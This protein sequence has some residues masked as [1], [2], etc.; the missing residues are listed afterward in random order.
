[1][2]IFGINHSVGKYFLSLSPLLILAGA[3]RRRGSLDRSFPRWK[4]GLGNKR[5]SY[6]GNCP[7]DGYE[8]R[9]LGNRGW[10]TSGKLVLLRG[11]P[12]ESLNFQTDSV[13]SLG[14][15]MQKTF[16]LPL[17]FRVLLCTCG[18]KGH[19]CLQGDRIAIWLFP[20]TA[21]KRGQVPL[22]LLWERAAKETPF[23]N[24]ELNPPCPEPIQKPKVN[25]AISPFHLQ[26]C[27]RLPFL[28]CFWRSSSSDS[29]SDS[30]DDSDSE[31][32]LA[33]AM[34]FSPMCS[35]AIAAWF[36]V[37][38]NSVQIQKRIY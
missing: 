12:P 11:A 10:D 1:M 8:N 22:L 6:L 35:I 17:S 24:G 28:S 13:L 32:D 33:Y 31:S 18:N 3:E 34:L 2:Y 20:F 15:K 7:G 5:N 38:L 9:H 16:S 27:T 30:E 19:C 26:S 29:D 4:E 21:T 25:C 36:A 37:C 23:A 14:G